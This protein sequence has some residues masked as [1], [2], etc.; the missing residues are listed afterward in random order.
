MNLVNPRTFN[1]EIIYLFDPW[2]QSESHGEMHHHDF[3]EISIVLEGESNYYFEEAPATKIK[4]GSIMLFNPG[5]NHCEFQESGTC[6]H[7]LHIGLKNISLEGFKRNFFPNKQPLLDL[8]K[9]HHQVL[10][11]AWQLVRESNEEQDE[12]QLMQKAL[13]I[14]MLVY[15]LR[16]LNDKRL[17]VVPYLTESQR[18]HQQI[19]NYTIYFLE[20]HYKEEITLEK[21]AQDQFLSPTY[22]S[23]V[24]KEAT[25]VSPINY[26]IEI[27][28]K[29]ARDMLTNEKLTIKEVASAVGYQD[30]YHFS[31]SF[32]KLFGVSPSSVIPKLQK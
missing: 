25:G 15:I 16:G 8:G 13:I 14:E 23:K 24:F 26:L 31:K 30:A 12:F 3:L 27:R 10:D 32:K 9:Y 7:Q 1:P 2:T 29:R 4:A 6:S 20:N 17:N 18:R 5:V 11:K 19:V 28:L 21:L 22:L